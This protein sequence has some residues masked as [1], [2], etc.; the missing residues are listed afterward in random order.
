VGFF[1]GQSD[2]GHGPTHQE[3]AEVNKLASL[4]WF[5]WG[6]IEGFFENIEEY[7]DRFPIWRDELYLEFHR[8]CFSNHPRVK[9]YNRK[10]ENLM[11]S[12]ESLGVLTQCYRAD[13]HYPQKAMEDLWKITLKNQFHDILPGSSI[14]EVYDDF[15]EDWL[16]QAQKV[17]ELKEVIG[18]NLGIS[19]STMSD[20]SETHIF[21]YNPLSWKRT[22]RVFIPASVFGDSLDLDRERNEKPEFAVLTLLN[23]PHK[24]YLCQPVGPDPEGS[25]DPLPAGWWTVLPLDPLSINAAKIEII[26]GDNSTRIA[27]EKAIAVSSKSISNGK[28]SVKINQENGAILNLKHEDINEGSNL[29][30]GDESNLLFGFLDRVPIRYHAWNLTPDYWEHPLD[31]SHGKDLQITV[32]EQGPVFSTIEIRKSLGKSPVRQ[33]ITLFKDCSE[34]F[35]D[36][37]TDWRRKDS[38]VKIK[39]IPHTNSTEVTADGMACAISSQVDPETPCDKARF[40]KICHQYCDLSTPAHEWG[41]ALLNEGKYAFDVLEDGL[42]LTLLRAC[43]YPETAPEAWV[44]KERKLNKQEFD[45]EVPEYSG[46]GPMSCRYALLPHNGGALRDSEGNPNPIVTRKANEFNNPILVIPTKKKL[47][48]QEE[49][50]FE[51]PILTITPENV[52]LNALKPEEWK[53]SKNAIIVRFFEFCGESR[54]ATA[55]FNEQL[56]SR[57]ENV[58][59]VDLLERVVAR[60]FTYQDKGILRFPIGKFELRTF[61]LELS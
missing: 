51:N 2:G 15:W 36:F 21:L 30:K 34:V 7:S 45:H 31:F 9:R 57:I 56:S 53:G 24:K 28:V 17:N 42:R 19:G 50:A 11:T 29:L 47:T 38:M 32:A 8:G 52:R 41:V 18:K 22:A 4:K 39:Y 55:K 20:T 46:L 54:E 3:V 37:Y 48:S 59:A 33:Q 58:Q 40:E 25:I 14:P 35:L 10:F 61:K 27:K 26:D 16:N 44:N 12:L 5:K 49:N 43:R 13:Y 23:N 1:F 60:E 6:S